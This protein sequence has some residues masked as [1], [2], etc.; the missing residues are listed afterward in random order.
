MTVVRTERRERSAIGKLVKWLFIG[1]NIFCAIWMTSGLSAVSKIQTHSSAEQIG[2][3]IGATLGFAAIGSIWLFGAILLG[4]LVLLSRGDTIIIEEKPVSR[5]ENASGHLSPSDLSRAD[6]R[7]AEMIA[8]STMSKETTSIQT[9][10]NSVQQP[11]GFG[12]RRTLS[13]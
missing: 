8:A 1:F 5:S 11:Q 4:I 3:N 10:I 13:L 9:K 2:A 7:I 12:K 6:A